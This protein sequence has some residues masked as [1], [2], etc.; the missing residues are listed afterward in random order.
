MRIN[1]KERT[2][3]DGRQLTLSTYPISTGDFGDTP[4]SYPDPIHS[5][6]WI[7]ITDSDGNAR[8]YNL[9]SLI[10]EDMWYRSINDLLE[11][12]KVNLHSE[13]VI[14]VPYNRKSKSRRMEIIRLRLNPINVVKISGK[15]SFYKGYKQIR[16]LESLSNYSRIAL[17]LL[18]QDELDSSFTILNFP[19]FLVFLM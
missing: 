16:R 13:A 18:T 4:R 15:T 9:S 10:E 6:K 3:P 11:I 8:K 14:Y 1:A 5:V 17:I 7:P 12:G 19:R 2:G